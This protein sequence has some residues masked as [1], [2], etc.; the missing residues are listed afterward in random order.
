MGGNIEI[1][2]GD[3]LESNAEIIAHQVNMQGVMGAGLAKTIKKRYPEVYKDYKKRYKDFRLGENLYSV[4]KDSRIVANMFGQ[5]NYGY[6]GQYTDYDALER[7]LEALAQ[8]CEK[9]DVTVGLPYGLGCGRGGGDWSEVYSR[10]N[11][12]FKNC[13]LKKVKIYKL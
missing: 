4:T 5:N 2:K 3:L 11:K 7:C 6:Y 10:M 9:H 8:L 13:N 1:V 12:V